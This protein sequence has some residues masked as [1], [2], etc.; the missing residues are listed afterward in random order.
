LKK[1]HVIFKGRVQGVGFRFLVQRFANNMNLDGFVRNKADGSVELE[2]ECS[3]EQFL[4]L[5]DEIKKYM[6]RNIYD[7]ITEEFEAEGKH[8][9]FVIRY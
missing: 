3:H 5:L 7:I 9:G 1:Y 2:I 8:K 4:K 6:E